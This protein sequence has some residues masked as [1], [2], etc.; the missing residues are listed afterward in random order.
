[1]NAETKKSVAI[2]YCRVSRIPDGKNGILSLDSQEAYIKNVIGN[3]GVYSVLKNVGSA[4]NNNQDDLMYLLNSCKNKNLIVYEA[5]RLSRNLKNFDKIWKI[6]KKNNHDIYIANTN[7][8][9]MNNDDSS[10]HEL[11]ELIK[12]A[13]KESYDLGR[14]VSRTAQF[15]KSRITAWGKKRNDHD[16]IIDDPYELEISELIRLLSTK[17]SSIRE[18]SE[19]I[20]ILRTDGSEEPFEIVEYTKGEGT[21]SDVTLT[22]SHMPY[23]MSFKDIKDTLEVYGIRYRNRIRWDI[24]VIRDIVFR[25]YKDKRYQKRQINEDDICDEFEILGFKKE[26]NKVEGKQENKVECKEETN[27]AQWYMVFYDPSIGLP[28]H[29]ILPPGFSLPNTKCELWIPKSK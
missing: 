29:V 12:Q 19:M 21:S 4:Y 17:G 3:M 16:E 8:W 25:T 27:E 13:E 22:E 5:N 24:N 20:N 23:P 6:C 1:M 9:Y 26:E 10:Y 18:I 15:K 7:N 11:F 2:I 28:P 14:R